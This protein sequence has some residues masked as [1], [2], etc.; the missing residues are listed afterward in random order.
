MFI[1]VLQSSFSSLMSVIADL[2]PLFILGA[3]AHTAD[4]SNITVNSG[5]HICVSVRACVFKKPAPVTP[6]SN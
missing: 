6:I 5:V 1:C 4:Q 3:I 2:P